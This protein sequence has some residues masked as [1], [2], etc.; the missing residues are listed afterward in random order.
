MLI[1]RIARIVGRVLPI[2]LAT[3]W[4]APTGFT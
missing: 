4:L 1:A 3:I 2:V